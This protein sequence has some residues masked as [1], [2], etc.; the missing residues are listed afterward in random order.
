MHSKGEGGEDVGCLVDFGLAV[1]VQNLEAFAL[2]RCS[3]A[4]MPSQ[5][6]SLAF[7]RCNQEMVASH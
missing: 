5:V 7:V 1:P 6:F 2:I 4:A 3:E